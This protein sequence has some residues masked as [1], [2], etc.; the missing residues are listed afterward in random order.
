MPYGLKV[1]NTSGTVQVDETYRN[2]ELIS[3]TTISTSAHGSSGGSAVM[4]GSHFTVTVT[5]GV[6]P[7][8]AT[9]CSAEWVGLDGKGSSRS[10]S[11]F[12]FHFYCSGAAGTSVTVYVFDTPST[13]S[14]PSSNYGLE[15]KNAAG[16]RCYNSGLKY[17]RVQDILTFQVPTSWT[18]AAANSPWYFTRHASWAT[19]TYTTG[20]TYAAAFTLGLEIE[21]KTFNSGGSTRGVGWMVIGAKCSSNTV[22]FRECAYQYY[23][24][25]SWTYFN[26]G[27]RSQAFVLDVTNY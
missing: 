13:P 19:Y 10:G 7:I 26:P 1:I 4:T 11:T 18:Y 25:S 9:A 27:M 14:T 5:G 12:T 16:A 22:D 23:N 15:V 20:R 24:T 6:N 3:K 8:V 21:A 2:L 17:L